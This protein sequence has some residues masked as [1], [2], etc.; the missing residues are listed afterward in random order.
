[1]RILKSLKKLVNSYIIDSP[2]PSNI[3]YLWNFGSL[4]AACLGIWLILGL[5]LAFVFLF[6]VYLSISLYSSGQGLKSPF[7]LHFFISLPAQCKLSILPYIK[8]ALATVKTKKFWYSLLIIAIT[9]F[10]SRFIIKYYG[11]VDVL[12]DIYDK[13]SLIYYFIFGGWSILIRQF[14]SDLYEDAPLDCFTWNKTTMGC[15]ST[16]SHDIIKLKSG[17]YWSCFS[18]KEGPEASS[19]SNPNPQA[20]SSGGNLN[21]RAPFFVPTSG[22]SNLSSTNPRSGTPDTILSGSTLTN[23]DNTPPR[24]PLPARGTISN[25]TLSQLRAAYITLHPVYVGSTATFSPATLRSLAQQSAANMSAEE[26]RQSLRNIRHGGSYDPITN[27]R[28]VREDT[29]PR[30]YNASSSTANSYNNSRNGR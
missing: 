29:P 1:M 16:K 6:V 20:N 24:P 26:L 17:S 5:K 27:P 21:P 8:N 13:V 9:G 7:K 4:L 30:I 19:S 14:F 2:Q 15:F 18:S 28:P 12:S 11:D 22:G 3:S 10:F 25:M 23:T